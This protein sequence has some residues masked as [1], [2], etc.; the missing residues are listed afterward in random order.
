M[1]S[2][3]RSCLACRIRVD[4]D[5]PEITLLEGRCPICGA[6]LRPVSSASAVV[7]LRLFDL[8]ALSDQESIDS[9]KAPP[10]TPADIVARR[11]GALGREDLDANRWVARG[12]PTP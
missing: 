3:H 8:D 9:P 1:S 11:E 6:T 2:R 10:G 7:G 5:A 4:A 12:W